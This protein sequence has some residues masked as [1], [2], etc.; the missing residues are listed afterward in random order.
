MR[1][2]FFYKKKNKKGYLIIIILVFLIK[3]RNLNLTHNNM[4]KK[5][6][7][8]IYIQKISQVMILK[9]KLFLELFFL[10]PKTKV[11]NLINYCFL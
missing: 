5:I 2:N 4:N 11:K 8:K 1:P 6:I 9:I 10:M 3:C 7:I